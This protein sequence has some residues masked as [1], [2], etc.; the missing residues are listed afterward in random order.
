ML[1]SWKCSTR[2]QTRPEVRKGKTGE[3]SLSLVA[4]NMVHFWSL[5]LSCMHR[6]SGTYDMCLLS[7]CNCSQRRVCR[8]VSTRCSDALMKHGGR[9]EI[10]SP[11]P[12]SPPPH[13][14]LSYDG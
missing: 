4:M 14:R 6:R 9:P 11:N 7:L 2:R 3:G 1:I 8:R 10:S 12:V 13:L 5:T